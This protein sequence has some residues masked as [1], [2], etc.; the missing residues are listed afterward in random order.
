ME[1]LDNDDLEKVSGGSH[2]RITMEPRRNLFCPWCNAYEDVGDWGRVS[3]QY[4]KRKFTNIPLLWCYN[5]K[6]FFLGPG[7]EGHYYSYIGDI[8]L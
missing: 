3:G 5:S 4:G 6:K 1:K 8:I 7:R 2:G